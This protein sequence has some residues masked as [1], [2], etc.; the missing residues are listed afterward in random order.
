MI[1]AI[2]ATPPAG[3]SIHIATSTAR[4]SISLRE[5][6][7]R[8][9]RVAAY[10]RA[11]GIRP[12][13]RIGILSSNRLEWVLLDLAALRLE[14]ETA[15]L[16]PGKFEPTSELLT[17]YDLKVLFTDTPVDLPG[18]L[19]IG[20]IENHSDSARSEVL[21][22]VS[23]A[24]EGIT[25][26]K[27][28]S[29]S[30]GM[31]KGL[32]ATAGSIDSSVTAIQQMFGHGPGD[33]LL[34]FL[35]LSL[36]QQ[37]YWIY[38]A[39]AYG[40]DVTL[41]TY[42]SVFAV[43]A[44]VRPTVVMG[45]PAFFEA[46][47]REI[48][49]SAAEIETDG[50]NEALRAAANE[51]FGGRIRYLWTGSAP[52]GRALL[53]F[54]ASV[55]LAIFEGYGLNETCIVAKNSP[56]AARVGSVGRV[57]RG[58]TVLIDEEGV[59]RVRS[60]YP[61]SHRYLYAEPGASERVFCGDNTVITRDVG[62]LDS[63]G[64]LYILGRADDTIVLDNGRKIIVRAIEE[65]LT[66]AGTTIIECVVFCRAQTELVAVASSDRFPADRDAVAAQLAVANLNAHRDERISRIV[67]TDEPFSIGNGLL[68]SQYK[69]RRQRIYA[70]F[71]TALTNPEE[72]IHAR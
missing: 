60:E 14:V 17:R 38:S 5:L 32:A 26:I 41:C 67:L 2:I 58:K 69:P 52:A 18:I 70:R 30:T 43:M 66:G 71:E 21:P 29:G 44:S 72:G 50:A 63:D 24:P 13:D 33:N 23:Y 37:R 27:F 25:T 57:L 56:G 51:M 35:P 61:V 39:L 10:L 20:D 22:L 36:L 40:H 34:V 19:A 68:T 62:Y 16:E 11:L 3:G 15:G 42:T 7:E 45:V 9:G 46:A 48:E 54:F 8:A 4:Q 47:R 49:Q 6:Y 53:D 28:T 64:Y 59:V 65:R 12:G 55:G 31:P 1:N